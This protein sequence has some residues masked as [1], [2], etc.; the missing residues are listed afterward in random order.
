MDPSSRVAIEVTVD[1]DKHSLFYTL[2]EFQGAFYNAGLHDSIRFTGTESLP[3]NLI[4]I[5][6][7]F[8]DENIR[9]SLTVSIWATDC[10]PV[11]TP[12]AW[13]SLIDPPPPGQLS[14][15][16]TFKRLGNM[17]A[18]QDLC[19][20]M[21]A[22]DPLQV[23]TSVPDELGGTFSCT[24]Q[25]VT[26]ESSPPAEI[27]KELKFRWTDASGYEFSDKFTYWSTR[28]SMPK[29]PIKLSVEP[30]FAG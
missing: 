3:N 4:E 22:P 6:G 11:V 9:G 1:K 20:A 19:D 25:P 16:S 28:E 5:T 26:P 8:G 7:S 13:C 21:I 29:F 12:Q 30:T 17:Q 23:C 10:R 24:K 14:L 27:A 18:S 2:T 15:S